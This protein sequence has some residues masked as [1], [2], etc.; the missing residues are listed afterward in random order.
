[1]DGWPSPS[2][3]N[4]VSLIHPAPA[5][6]ADRQSLKC[7]K[8]HADGAGRGKQFSAPHRIARRTARDCGKHDQAGKGQ[9]PVAVAEDLQDARCDGGLGWKAGEPAESKKPAFDA[10]PRNK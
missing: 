10:V 2:A 4:S 7:Q 8:Q 9:P 3:P 6:K 5:G 1:M